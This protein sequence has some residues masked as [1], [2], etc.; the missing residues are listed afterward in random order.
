[1][2]IESATAQYRYQSAKELAVDMRR[3]L[4]PNPATHPI[5]QRRSSIGKRI[6]IA[7]ALSV[8]VLLA[9]IS[10]FNPGGASNKLFGGKAHAP[11]RSLVVLPLANLSGDPEQEYFADG[12]TEALITDLENP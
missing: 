11:I 7:A 4:A 2:A 1:V 9:T 10:V 8:A 12:M 5:S 6:S 3:L